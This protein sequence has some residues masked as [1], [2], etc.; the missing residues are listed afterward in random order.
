MVVSVCVCVH[1]CVHVCV[2]VCVCGGGA[3]VRE[4]VCVYVCVCARARA[5]VLMCVCARAR[6]CVLLLVVVLFACLLFVCSLGVG[7][8][9]ELNINC[10]DVLLGSR[11]GLT[12]VPNPLERRPETDRAVLSLF[13]CGSVCP[14]PL[15]SSYLFFILFLTLNRIDK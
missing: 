6:V 4:C 10:C 5:C 7:G 2:C 14:F 8:G 3:R 13:P 11:T 9:G 1:V 15:F 12:G